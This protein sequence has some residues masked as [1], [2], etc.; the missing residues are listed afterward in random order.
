VALCGYGDFWA[1]TS[2]MGSTTSRLMAQ[3]MLTLSSLDAV[4]QFWGVSGR[5]GDVNDVAAGQFD[6]IDG[7]FTKVSD[8]IN[9]AAD[10]VP[11]RW[12]KVL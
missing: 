4:V 3:L 12:P 2:V 11:G 6:L 5:C 10:L 9:L 1:L 7:R 8:V